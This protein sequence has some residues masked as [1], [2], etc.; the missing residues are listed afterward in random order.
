MPTISRLDA[1]QEGAVAAE[2]EIAR[3]RR[4]RP[5]GPDQEARPGVQSG[6]SM[7]SSDCRLRAG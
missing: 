5:V 1:E 4:A 6:S 7:R 2:T 3:H